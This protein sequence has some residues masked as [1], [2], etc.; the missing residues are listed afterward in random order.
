M[1]YIRKGGERREMALVGIERAREGLE[2]VTGLRISSKRPNEEVW[3][4][5][6]PDRYLVFR[7]YTTDIAMGKGDVRYRPI[8]LTAIVDYY[9]AFKAEYVLREKRSALEALI[10]DYLP[11]EKEG[12]E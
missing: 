12:S 5:S 6:D 3:R 1:T 2:A 8:Q 11:K 4:G 10:A 7:T 9:E